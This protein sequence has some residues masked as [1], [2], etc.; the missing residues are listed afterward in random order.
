MML[1]QGRFFLQ[2]LIVVVLGHYIEIRL[3]VVMPEAA[4]LGADD[5]IL[6]NFGCGKVQRNVQSGNKVLLDAQ[7]RDKE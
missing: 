6:A 1:L 5:F 2:P 7:L 4:K 3:H